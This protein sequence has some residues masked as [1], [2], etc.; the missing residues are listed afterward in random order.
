M[1]FVSSSSTKSIITGKA[2]RT[3]RAGRSSLV[4]DVSDEVPRDGVV[5]DDIGLVALPLVVDE[6][7]AQLLRVSPD[8]LGV[9]TSTSTVT[10]TGWVATE[11]V[12]L[13]KPGLGG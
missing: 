11:H 2:S 13:I 10:E 9:V 7:A 8:N 5:A 3:L 6:A 4:H 12:H 1:R